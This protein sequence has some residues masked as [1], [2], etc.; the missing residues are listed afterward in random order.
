[1]TSNIDTGIEV[2]VKFRRLVKVNLNDPSGG[3]NEC[4]Q[5]L[6][7]D[8]EVETVVNEMNV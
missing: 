5:F 3:V 1:M 7:L 8:S 4:R 6:P 2:K